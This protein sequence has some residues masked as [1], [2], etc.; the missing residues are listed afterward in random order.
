MLRHRTIIQYSDMQS[1]KFAHSCILMKTL[2]DEKNRKKIRGFTC[3]FINI[4]AAYYPI[5]YKPWYQFNSNTW[6]V[7]LMVQY[8]NYLKIAFMNIN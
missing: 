2:E 4:S 5:Y 3:I 6:H 8:A 7:F 1:I